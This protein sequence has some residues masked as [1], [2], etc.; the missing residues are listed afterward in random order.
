MFYL[1]NVRNLPE[2]LTRCYAVTA[3]AAASHGR[4]VGRRRQRYTSAAS[5]HQCRTGRHRMRCSATG[6]RSDPRLM[7]CNE[8]VVHRRAATV[9]ATNAGTAPG[10]LPRHRPASHVAVR[11]QREHITGAAAA[12]ADTTPANAARIT[13]AAAITA[14][15]ARS[16]TTTTT[17]A[18]TSTSSANATRTG[19]RRFRPASLC[20]ERKQR[21]IQRTART[22]AM[23]SRRRRRFHAQQI[24]GIR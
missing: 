17:S 23:R 11:C 21:T 8:R 20:V 4:L 6:H 13:A 12:N 16:T 3:I 9:A 7:P 24:A 14:S 18:A 10:R 19:R 1:S 5:A 22:T 15:S 2:K